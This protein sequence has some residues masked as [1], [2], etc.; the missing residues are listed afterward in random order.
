MVGSE[1]RLLK[2]LTP[3]LGWRCS[4][5]FKSVAGKLWKSDSDIDLDTEF[6]E[7]L[8]KQCFD[9]NEPIS[10]GY[11]IF[12]LVLQKLMYVRKLRLQNKISR[13]VKCFQNRLDIVY[14][15]HALKKKR[16]N[17]C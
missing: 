16:N 5:R 6:T 9:G 15:V 10:K 14:R 8:T 2:P 1:K 7:L 4:K 3:P 13:F 11:D 12:V 17:T